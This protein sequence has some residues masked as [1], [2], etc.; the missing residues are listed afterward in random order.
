VTPDGRFLVFESTNALTPDDIRTDGSTQIF[1]YDAESEA[2]VRI[3]IGNQGFNDNGNAGT[4]SAS[5]VP[6][7]AVAE[8]PDPLRG[9]PTMSND[10][11]YVFFQSPLGLTPHALNDVVA[12]ENEGRTEYAQNVYEYHAGHV[13]LVSSGRDANSAKTPCSFRVNKET[14]LFGS[15]VCLLGTDAA[16]A[17]VFFMTADQLAAADSDTQTDI[18]DARIC[19]PE[20]GNPC[21]QPAASSLPPC[22]GEDCHGIPAAT[23]AVLAPG[24][25]SFDGQGNITPPA[26]A[27]VKPKPPTNAQR[28]TKALKACHKVKKKKKRIT[29]EKRAHKRYGP[30]K[31]KKTK[32]ATNHRRAGR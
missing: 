28:L 24:S 7:G 29:C 5:I 1:G 12:G 27:A 30:S 19:E 16:G 9:D 8:A 25:A 3:S 23:P 2:L 17:N 21:L 26:R 15:T 4:G 22:G 18:Y 11:S 32:K 13:Y 14:E 31:A 20:D 6:S 10:G